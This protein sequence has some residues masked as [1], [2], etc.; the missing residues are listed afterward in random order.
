VIFVGNRG[1]GRAVACS[2][3]GIGS[4]LLSVPIPVRDPLSQAGPA[5]GHR[6][7]GRCS[8][9]ATFLPVVYRRVLCFHAT[10]LGGHG[11]GES[12][13]GQRTLIV[14]ERLCRPCIRRRP[15]SRFL[16]ANVLPRRRSEC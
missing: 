8:R 2:R 3:P 10:P 6:G 14:V 5:P 4:G 1:V 11:R 15:P 16:G 13:P 12:Y 7:H 9:L